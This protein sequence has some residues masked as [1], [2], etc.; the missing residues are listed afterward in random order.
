MKTKL[1]ITLGL[2]AIAAIAVTSN[3]AEAAPTY[4]RTAYYYFDAAH[5]QYAGWQQWNAC[6]P[7][8]GMLPVHGT[9]TQYYVLE[10]EAC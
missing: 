1:M 10:V 7:P 8:Y 6:Q 9:K 3:R 2:A 5:T 4:A